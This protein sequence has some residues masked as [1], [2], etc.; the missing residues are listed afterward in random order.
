MGVDAVKND[1]AAKE[2][3]ENIKTLFR[4]LQRYLRTNHPKQYDLMKM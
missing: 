2:I 4:Q 3:F 1:A